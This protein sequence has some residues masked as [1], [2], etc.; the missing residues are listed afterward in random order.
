MSKLNRIRLF[1]FADQ[2]WCP[3]VVRNLLTR[4]L[5]YQIAHYD[6][7]KPIIPILREALSRTGYGQV[8]DLCSG[9]GG[10]WLH[11]QRKFPDLHVT[12]TDRFPNKD[13]IRW[14]EQNPSPQLRYLPQPVDARLIPKELTGFRTCFTSFHHFN[15]VDA[16]SILRHAVESNV[17][18]GI[19]EFTERNA[20]NL[21]GMILSP[22]LVFHDMQSLQP[23]RWLDL[24]LTYLLPIIP[25]CY[26][27]DG[28]VSHWRTYNVDELRLLVKKLG[29]TN[30]VW[31]IDKVRHRS[32]N[33]YVTYLIGF[34]IKN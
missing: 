21:R 14:L 4:L 8:V 13:T 26:W 33:N 24:L 10:A 28:T 25:F 30:Y 29:E 9:S 5:S 3:S 22:L 18:I 2:W 31:E 17:P 12:L 15:P 32:N 7:Y 34:P 1:E 20:S 6:L 23:R 19:F 27:W 11:L 16:I